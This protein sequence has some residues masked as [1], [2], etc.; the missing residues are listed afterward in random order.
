MPPPGGFENVKYKRNLPFRGPSGAV[1]LA[2]VFGVCAFGFYKLGQ[3][4]L[5]KRCVAIF[6]QT[7]FQNSVLVSFP[8]YFVAV[9]SSFFSCW[10]PFLLP[11]ATISDIHRLDYQ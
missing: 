2:G 7:L 9:L 11:A 5:E 4:N 8:H 10:N 1:V 3:G 6:F